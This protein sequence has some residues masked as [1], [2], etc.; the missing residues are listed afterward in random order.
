M[1]VIQA[2]YSTWT[3]TFATASSLIA[4]NVRPLFPPVITPLHLTRFSL[5]L[6]LAVQEN[7]VIKRYE[8][9]PP[10]HH[11][12]DAQ[13]WRDRDATRL[14][15]MRFSFIA[16]ITL[17]VVRFKIR[18]VNKREQIKVEVQLVDISSSICIPPCG[19]PSCINVFSSGPLVVRR[20]SSVLTM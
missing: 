16:T 5:S 15:R 14:I 9:L 19:G 12:D 17:V 18:V 8:G 10:R 3:T 4:H 13:Y 1:H 6:S 7:N 20:L 2:H 11:S